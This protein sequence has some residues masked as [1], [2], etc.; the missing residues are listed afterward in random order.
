MNNDSKSAMDAMA[1]KVVQA[2]A[3]ELG[4]RQMGIVVIVASKD[5]MALSA[6]V[7]AKTISQMLAS[8]LNATLNAWPAEEQKLISVPTMEVKKI[9]T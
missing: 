1:Q 4:I 2:H 7:N 6:S 3:A 9:V 8:G 5:G